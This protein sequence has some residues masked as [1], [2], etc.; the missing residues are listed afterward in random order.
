[1]TTRKMVITIEEPT[2]ERLQEVID[3]LSYK[4]NNKHYDIHEISAWRHNSNTGTGTGWEMLAH[5]DVLNFPAYYCPKCE[6]YFNDTV[7][8]CTQEARLSGPPEDCWPEE[9][10]NGCPHCGNKDIEEVATCDEE[11]YTIP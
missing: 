10:Y 7:Y 6:D 5:V 9:G 4:L 11:D 8:V 2:K 1:M 3:I